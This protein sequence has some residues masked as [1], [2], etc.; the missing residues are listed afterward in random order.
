MTEVK[1]FKD[2]FALNE[3]LKGKLFMHR[4]D[5]VPVPRMFENPTN[6]L[7]VSVITYVLIMN[8]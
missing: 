1:E 7:I 6:K 8:E 4:Y 3:F 5:I 2:I